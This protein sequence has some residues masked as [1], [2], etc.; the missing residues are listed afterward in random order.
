MENKII[1]CDVCWGDGYVSACC[2]EYYEMTSNN[3]CRC[4]GCGKFCR[5]TICPDCGGEGEI[6]ES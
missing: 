3:M 6:D 4:E 5:I 2:L 1:T